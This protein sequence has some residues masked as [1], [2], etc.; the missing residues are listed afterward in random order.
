MAGLVAPQRLVGAE[1]LAAD[2]A[3]ELR[4]DRRRGRD[5]RRRRLDAVVAAAGEHEEAEREVLLL[6]SL[7]ARALLLGPP[8]GHV[9]NLVAA[10]GGGA[11]ARGRGRR[12]RRGR[13]Q[14]LAL[15]LRD[16]GVEQLHGRHGT[17]S[18]ASLGDVETSSRLRLVLAVGCGVVVAW[19]ALLSLWCGVVCECGE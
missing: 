6:R 15:L 3:P 17:A 1:G 19:G 8:L 9:G 18:L 2:G 10:H 4:G 16:D 7:A 14:L 11:A 12:R 5:Q 13:H